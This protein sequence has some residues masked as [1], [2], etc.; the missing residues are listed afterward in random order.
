MTRF[1]T[2]PRVVLLV[3]W[4]AV[5]GWFPPTARAA[6]AAPGQASQVPMKDDNVV[7]ERNGVVVSRDELRDALRDAR[8]SGDSKRMA[9]TMTV[10]GLEQLARAIL[11]RKLLA[12]EAKSRG[13]DK[14]P[15][16]ERTIASAV[17]TFLARQLVERL[18][19]SVD[20]SDTALQRYY[21][22]HPSEFRGIERRR[23]HHIVVKTREEAEAAFIAVN[24]GKPLEEIASEQ[25]TDNTKTGRGD[26]GWVPRGRMV[27]TFDDA[28][29]ALPRS[30]D[31]S[32]IVQTTFGYHLI[33]LDEIDSGELPAF[34]TVKDNVKRAV[35]EHALAGLKQTIEAH[36][37]SI[38]K[39]ALANLA[40]A[41]KRP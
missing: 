6:Q 35:I 19:A 4:A 36:P 8:L 2:A 18:A 22:E 7:A 1:T 37:A 41:G 23:A 9:D 3:S 31:L 14:D 11:E 13:L 21:H 16:V 32:G 30:G 33:R 38:D 29:F 34:E 26:L 5:L 20:T 24:A 27:K 25:N 40:G 28:L 12:R 10:D 39:D 15:A 17:D